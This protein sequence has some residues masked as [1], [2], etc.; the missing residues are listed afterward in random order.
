VSDWPPTPN[1]LGETMSC[2]DLVELVTDYLEGRISSADR[3]LVD[4]HLAV[5]PPCV[6][7]L[8]QMRAT[9]RALG[10]IPEESIPA[11]AREELIHAFRE[12]HA[13]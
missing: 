4:A 10:R 8:D 13:D 2:S 11:E 6:I 12:L 1:T 3:E 5:C 7:Y 9:L